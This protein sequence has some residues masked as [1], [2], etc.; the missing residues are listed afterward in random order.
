[1]RSDHERLE[2]RSLA[3]HKELAERLR[4]NPQLIETAKG[5]LERWA[6]R[7]GD[8]PAWREWRGILDGSLSQILTMLLS[9]DERGRRLRQSSP[10]CGILTPRQRWGIYE[11]FTVGAYHK[12]DR[13]HRG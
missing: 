13:Q 11:S 2:D 5:N 1:M 7:D 6:K 9:D 12:G 3:L 8:L 10:F 4:E